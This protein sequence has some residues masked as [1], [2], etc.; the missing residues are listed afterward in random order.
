MCYQQLPK[1]EYPIPLSRKQ[2]KYIRD[3]ELNDEDLTIY[4]KPPKEK[5]SKKDLS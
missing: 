1:L 3:S 4:K 2:I 5:K